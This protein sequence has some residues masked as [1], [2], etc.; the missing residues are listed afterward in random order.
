MLTTK[1]QIDAVLSKLLEPKQ[2]LIVGKEEQV[3]DGLIP[4]YVVSAKHYPAWLDA[5]DQTA[6][7][8]LVDQGFKAKPKA[9]TQFPY[10]HKDER[11]SSIA[12]LLI[13]DLEHPFTCFANA[14]EK[15]PPAMYHLITNEQNF[16]KEQA[17]LGWALNGYGFDYFNGKATDKKPILMINE[18]VV[19]ASVLSMIDAVYL[20]RDLINLP[21]SH[22]NPETLADHVKRLAA[23]YDASYHCVVGDDLLKEN[24]PL[25]YHVGKA[26]AVSPRLIE[27]NW[28]PTTK[29]AKMQLTLVGKGVTFD[30]GGLDLKPAS[31]M[32]LMKKDMGGAASAIAT[33][34]AIMALDLPVDLR[35]LVPCC[36]NAVSGNAYRPQD[37]LIS[38]SGLSVEIGDTD[39]EGRLILA[40]T[41]TYAQEQPCDFL[42]DFATLTGAARVALGAE[43]PALFTNDTALADEMMKLGEQVKD[44]CWRLPLHSEY[45][46]HVK[47]KVAS[48]TNA[49]AMGYGGAIH[50][51]LFLQHFIKPSQCWAHFDMMG[52]NLS[53]RNGFPEGGEPNMVRTIL[54]WIN[55][56]TT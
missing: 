39:A 2:P 16:D 52:W 14:A 32:K 22:L 36:E 5:L 55:T 13:L 24:F 37:V 12:A 17:Y 7:N 54:H 38:R 3:T 25:I 31:G 28:K 51:A 33:A 29:P 11:F 41:L 19:P 50:A 35:L 45:D 8:W 53:R 47:G 21:A 48:I 20:G 6:R 15:L 44:P 49:P 27:V 34:M 9:V 42:I 40:D 1:Q 4:L 23:R 10:V 26:S 18:A 43:L 46:R 56:K 30:S